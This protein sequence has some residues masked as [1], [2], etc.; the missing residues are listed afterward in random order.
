MGWSYW[1]HDTMSGD[2]IVQVHP[3]ACSGTSRLTG[4]GD[5]TVTFSL[6]GTSIPLP[7]QGY[8]TP[9]SR[10]LVKQWDRPGQDPIVQFAGYFIE[11][12][13]DKDAASVTVDAKELRQLL[14]VRPFGAAHL[15]ASDP[16]SW[17]L[18]ITSRS[19]AG[20]VRALLT[21][22]ITYSAE[23]AL[24]LDLPADGSGTY[25]RDFHAWDQITTA[26]ALADIEAMGYEVHF[27]PY[28]TA[29][30]LR[31]QVLV[32]P[33]VQLTPVRDLAG[34]T[35][36][37]PVV[38]LRVR[39]PGANQL[40]G[41]VAVGK[42]TGPD[43]KL[44]GAT[45][46]PG[47]IPARDSK[48]SAKDIDDETQLQAIADAEMAAAASVTEDVSFAVRLA[49]PVDAGWVLPGTQVRIDMTGDRGWPGVHT[50][51]VIAVAWDMTDTVTPE[52]V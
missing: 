13:Y 34:M 39:F 46:N 40:T 19:I 37:S 16:A 41:V 10:M 52:V 30:Q 28:K 2:P 51:R 47:V 27:R 4:R 25:S 50:K 12:E 29:G 7:W 26:D 9:T 18:R 22:A 45:S 20:A 38:G 11:P 17:E 49:D 14:D 31:F 8:T 3:A 42:G 33:K 6:D 43:T 35:P 44:R 32:A 48:V 36:E 5:A 21:R 1:I 15:V 23:S 24:P